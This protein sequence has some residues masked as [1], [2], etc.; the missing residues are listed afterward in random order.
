M[1]RKIY[2]PIQKDYVT[3]LK[4][5]NETNG[6]YTLVEVELADG[7]GV[8]LHYHKTY[9]EAFHCVEGEVQIKLGKIIHRLKEDE[10]AVAEKNINQFFRN[11]SGK[12][13]RF[14]VELRPGSRGFEQSLQIGY[15]LAQDG[16]CR[17]NGFPKD[18]LAL[19]WLFDISE[20]NLP[21]WMSIFE[22]I[23]R[24]QSKKAIAKGIDKTLID[25]YVK[26]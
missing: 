25:K 9:S 16:L 12:P 4:T 22:F 13:C 11:R 26:F 17:P 14:Q 10:S 21:G 15:G 2:N 6:E 20:S 23:L 5:T 3:F 7:G 18:R 19:A 24:R 1:E 8:G